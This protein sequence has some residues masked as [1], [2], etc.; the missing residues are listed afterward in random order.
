[1]RGFLSNVLNPKSVL[2][3]VSVVPGF[4]QYASSETE[5]LFQAARLGAIYVAIATAIHAS[6]VLLASRLRPLLIARA[7]EKTIRRILAFALVLV[8]AWLVWSTRRV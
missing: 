4:I 2:F 8:A 7:H 1:L 6:I 5:L 3:F